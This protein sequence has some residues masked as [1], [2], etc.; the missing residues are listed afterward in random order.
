MQKPTQQSSKESFGI[1]DVLYILFKHKWKIIIFSLAGFSA[2]AAVYLR[3]EPL[4]QSEAEIM[5]KY[6]LSRPSAD[7]VQQDTNTAGDPSVVAINTEI[8]ILK[9]EDIALKVAKAVGVDKLL[10]EAAGQ[11]TVVD[12][13]GK[14][15][16][17][18]EVAVVPMTNVLHI[19]Y[20]SSDPK[21]S[22]AVLGELLTQ[23]FER[24]L[25]IHRNKAA[26]DQVS[27]DT[28]QA[29]LRLKETESELGKLR[30]ESGI[31]GLADTYGTLSTQRTRAQEDL[32]AAEAELAELKGRLD[33][34]EK[35]AQGEPLQENGNPPGQQVPPYILVQYKS[36]LEV[37]SML[38]KRATEL[39]LKFKPGNRL[40][41]I[42]QEQ[43]ADYE[44]KRQDLVKRFPGLIAEAAK[45]EKELQNPQ[46]AVVSD[47]EKL[48]GL[49]AKVE[50]F[51]LKL[52]E[53]KAVFS[54]QYVIGAQIDALER[55]KQ[56]EESNYRSM[57]LK[58]KEAILD[59]KLASTNIPNIEMIQ[60]PTTPTYATY[61]KLTQKIVLGLAGGGMALGVGLAFLIELLLDRRV[62]R[63]TEIQAR[64]QLPLLLSIPYIR[65]K[66]RGG[67]LL[68]HEPDVPRIGNNGASDMD[69]PSR[70]GS[71]EAAVSRENHF[72]LPY[73]ET[74]RDRIIFNFEV[75]NVTHKPKLVAV[76][77]L[78]SGAGSSTIAAGLAK[79]FS[80]INGAKVLLVDLSSSSPE[81][82]LP[83]GTVARHSL[84]GALQLARNAAFKQNTQ[85]LYHASATARRD[86][87]GL[88]TFSPM[89]LY[90]LMPHLQASEFDYIV[91][92]MPPIDQTSRTLT[93]AGLMDKVLLVLDAENTSRDALKWGYS[94]LVK[95]RADVSCIFNKTRS[96]A[97]GWLL[98]KS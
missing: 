64:L 41:S 40:I 13:A 65:R 47:R 15:R 2:A 78:S 7:Q 68:S 30:T 16:A 17:S 62:K 94:E 70:A 86:D 80:E 59:R 81:Q 43:L 26:F 55:R 77:G 10:P 95:G 39:N 49:T 24:H 8:A 50:L 11:A 33:A 72:I 5:V 96:H 42:N 82:N 83:L 6:V 31:S 76:T 27:K 46:A 85:S 23:Y 34:V 56:M 79:S 98:G 14:V 3:R 63:P 32:M 91:F 84:T 4:Y 44:S 75:N 28:E 25:E 58:L 67:L 48:A 36:C 45:V 54:D 20:G 52:G 73:S 71:S 53:I 97:P 88:T 93:M 1:Q 66:E 87:S 38:E 18:T 37:L 9:S 69:V 74:I 92:D 12:G 19:T 51:R 90:E 29:R 21:L 89:H 60:N 61:D 22:M 57:E 35:P